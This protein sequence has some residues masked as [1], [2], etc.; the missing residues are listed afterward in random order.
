MMRKM[1]VS[2]KII[3]MLVFVLLATV[4]SCLVVYPEEEIITPDVTQDESNPVCMEPF[5]VD[6]LP[7]GYKAEELTNFTGDLNPVPPEKDW[8]QMVGIPTPYPDGVELLFSRKQNDQDELWVAFKVGNETQVR[9]Y[10]PETDKWE[11]KFEI[12]NYKFSF[13][14]YQNKVWVITSFPISLNNI[15]FK[16][17][18][19]DEQQ[20]ELKPNLTGQSVFSEG[21]V[22]RFAPSIDGTI[23]FIL[24]Q[25]NNVNNLLVQYDTE[26][27]QVIHREEVGLLVSLGVDNQ[28]RLFTA[29]FD[30]VIRRYD[31]TTG[32]SSDMKIP[33][34]FQTMYFWDIGFLFPDDQ[35]VWFSDKVW[36]TNDEYLTNLHTL[37]RSTIFINK[38]HDPGQ[39][40]R[41]ERPQVLTFTDDGRIWYRS[42]RGLTWHQPETGE[43]CMFTTAQS[44][45]VK[46][47]QGNLWIIYDNSLYMLPASET[48]AR[49][50]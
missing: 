42:S 39:P 5:F 24:D 8:E 12:E 26:T 1:M 16:I 38:Y 34:D 43:W 10:L 17:Y 32:E 29:S 4:P 22:Y 49:D 9:A 23:W 48:K 11:T 36:F 27:N 19:Y 6:S 7:Y 45:I 15:D 44:N 40:V 35:K 13:L 20:N 33:S 3:F 41:W 31:P 50:D 46:D 37:F 21:Q 47:S 25:A 18:E 14:D 30:D 2:S 28:G